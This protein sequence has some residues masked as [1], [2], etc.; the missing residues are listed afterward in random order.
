MIQEN[1]KNLHI[2]KSKLKIYIYYISW[3]G[4]ELSHVPHFLDPDTEELDVA[5][6]MILKLEAGLTFYSRL[7]SVNIS[8]N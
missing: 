7:L 8:G 5:G 6:N 4:G 2:F 1:M 3:T